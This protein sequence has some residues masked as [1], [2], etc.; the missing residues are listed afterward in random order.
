MRVEKY[1]LMLAFSA[2]TL[3]F[4]M[5][6][7]EAGRH[8]TRCAQAYIQAIQIKSEAISDETLD[9]WDREFHV[10]RNAGV[11]VV[12]ASYGSNG[13]TGINGYD[14]DDVSTDMTHPP[15]KRISDRTQ[16]QL[17]ITL[18]VAFI[19]WGV[20]FFSSLRSSEDPQ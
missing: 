13:V 5:P 7:L 8:E 17:L 20:S 4:G 2:I 18:F 9:P 10:R 19:P 1:S 16:R 14:D 3:W 6:N 11:I 12:V 15:H